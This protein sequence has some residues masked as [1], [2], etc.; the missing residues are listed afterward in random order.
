MLGS[1]RGKHVGGFAIAHQ[2]GQ[3]VRWRFVATEINDKARE[4]NHQGTPPLM[5]V[6]AIIS[7]AGSRPNKDGKHSRLVRSWDVR[8][9][10]FN[11]PIDELVF[12]H[13][14]AELCEKGWCWRLNKAMNGTR[15]ASQLWGEMV[16]DCWDSSGANI[17]RG[18]PGTVYFPATSAEADDD[19]TVTCHGDDF[20]AEGVGYILDE[21]SHVLEKHFEVTETGT[22]GPGYPGDFLYLKRLVGYTETLP[23]TGLP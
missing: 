16:K 8:K 11:A 3:K 6:R 12:V 1:Y 10:F 9:A 18:V 15:K 21:L 14:G 22:V 17:L 23:E 5:I 4:D 13:P 2:K 7:R 20:L 19:C